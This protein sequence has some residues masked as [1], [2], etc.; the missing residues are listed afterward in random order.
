M[1]SSIKECFSLINEKYDLSLY[2]RTYISSFQ[3]V[4]FN[5]ITYKM[6]LEGEVSKHVC[7]K[8]KK[9]RDKCYEQC[10]SM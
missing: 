2:N 6:V 3:D 7:F 10:N 8:E 4:N 5:K 1:Y 9:Y